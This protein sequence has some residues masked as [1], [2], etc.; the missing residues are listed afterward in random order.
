MALWAH[1]LLTT[2]HKK[3]CHL[4]PTRRFQF[5]SEVPLLQEPIDVQQLLAE[6]KGNRLLIQLW[7]APNSGTCCEDSVI[8][9]LGVPPW[10]GREGQRQHSS[11]QPSFCTQH[12]LFQLLFLC[13]LSYLF[14]CV[15]RVNKMNSATEAQHWWHS[16]FRTSHWI[17][18]SATDFL[19]K[20]IA[21]LE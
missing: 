10:T 4:K 21:I 20:V 1:T 9:S 6:E 2:R 11:F 13:I 3:Q 17:C 14:P 7:L 16:I 18:T 15:S 5:Y 19:Q 12:H 8:N